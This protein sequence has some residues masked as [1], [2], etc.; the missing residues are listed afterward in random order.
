MQLSQPHRHFSTASSLES[1]T[2]SSSSF[3]PSSA[4]AVLGL[5]DIDDNIDTTWGAYND[6]DD[7]KDGY[8]T[9]LGAAAASVCM[10]RNCALHLVLVVVVVVVLAVVVAVAAAAANNSNSS[11]SS[12][13]SILMAITPHWVLPPPVYVC[14]WALYVVLVVVVVLALCS[15]SDS[16]SSK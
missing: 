12:S 14:A 2:S 7:V 3:V 9:T 15:R 10:I 13:G 16:S 4:A 11:N 6:I 5:Y 1:P 8:Y